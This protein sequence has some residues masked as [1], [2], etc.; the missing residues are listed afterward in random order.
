MAEGTVASAI[1]DDPASVTA[2]VKAAMAGTQD[3][4]LKEIV[5]ALVDHG[6]A[7]LKQVK[8][9]DEEFERGLAFIRAAGHACNERHNEVVLLSDVLGFST[10]VALL[11]NSDATERT[12]GALLGPFYRSGSP[13]YENGQSIASSGSPGSPLFMRGCVVD[14]SGRPVKNALV[15]VW[16]ASPVGLYENQDQSQPDRN[17]RGRFHTDAKGWFNFKTVRPAGY[18]VPINGPVG[19]LLAA[20]NRHPYRPAHIHFVI[21]AEGHA[22]LVS[23]VFADDSEHLDSDVV[24]GVHRRLVGN[25]ERHDAETG[26]HADT[27]EVYYTL[28][29]EFVMADGTPTYPTP[30]I[31]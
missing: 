17:L 11:N 25:F 12:P 31:D 5:N 9:T 15:D 7:F 21:V 30:P 20:Q 4:R 19:T 28:D 2:I 10:L 13:V 18:P 16:Q 3:A 26:P 8:L 29:F 23:Q 22:T 6:H 24:F 14:V 1:T 27:D